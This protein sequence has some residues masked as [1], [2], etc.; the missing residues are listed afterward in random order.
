LAN[1]VTATTQSA[2]DASTK[3]ATTAYTD[4]AISNLVDSSPGALNTLNELAAAVGDD[5]NFSTTITNSI[6]TKMP[7]AGGEFTGNVTC[8]NIT[9]DADSSRNLGSNSVRFANIYGD[10]IY[11]DGSN[12]TGIVS[13]V[14]GMILLWSGS[15]GSIPSGWVLCNGSNST[16]DLRDRFVVGAMNAYSVGDTGGANTVTLSTAQLAAHSHSTN[17]HSH[18]FNAGNH[19]HSF[20]GSGSSSH[21]HSFDYQYGAPPYHSSGN[22]VTRAIWKRTNTEGSQNTSSATVSLSVSGN[23]GNG[24]VSGNTGNSNPST[25]NTGSGSSHENRPPYYALCYIMKT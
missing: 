1:G 12:L 15:S 9:P 2:G 23:T 18:S 5:A 4:T 17:N 22:K 16:P 13:F 14:S 24:A 6:A 8:E 3:V 10:T 19:T 25:N 21:S 11:G 7:L 20:S